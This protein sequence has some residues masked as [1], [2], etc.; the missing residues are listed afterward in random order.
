M[1]EPWV[2]LLLFFVRSTEKLTFFNHFISISEHQSEWFL[3]G[4]CVCAFMMLICFDNAGRTGLIIPVSIN[5]DLP[6]EHDDK[7]N[8]QYHL[9]GPIRLPEKMYLKRIYV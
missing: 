6:F 8:P 5:G 2:G 9:H 1:C 4:L 3:K 7:S